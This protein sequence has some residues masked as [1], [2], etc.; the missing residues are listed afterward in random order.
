MSPLSS[1]TFRVCHRRCA[2]TSTIKGS[3]SVPLSQ[4]GALSSTPFARACHSALWAPFS[5]PV[6]QVVV[7]VMRVTGEG[8]CRRDF[9]EPGL[10]PPARLPLHACDPLKPFPFGFRAM[11]GNKARHG[12]AQNG[13]AQHGARTVI[14]CQGASMH[15]HTYT[16]TNALQS[17][18]ST[19][20]SVSCGW[21]RLGL[22]WDLSSVCC[23]WKSIC[24]ILHHSQCV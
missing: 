2:C 18:L 9:N 23:H 1:P 13:T 19:Q 5:A 10:S 22:S 3:D 17:P 12:A 6:P 15:M 24:S 7:V 14:G 21:C 4:A 16:Q 20:P 11:S 8:F